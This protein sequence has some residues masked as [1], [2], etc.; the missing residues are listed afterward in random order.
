MLGKIL[1][2]LLA[3]AAVFG[4]VNGSFAEFDNFL[5]DGADYTVTFIVGIAGSICFFCGMANVA[6]E[7]GLTEKL[8]KLFSPVFKRLLPSA[9]KNKKTSENTILNISSNILG[10]GNAATPFGISAA[11]G[12]YSED[13][14]ISRSLAL[15]ILFNTSSVQ[16]IPS[17][18]I[19]VRKAA[20]ASDP[21]GVILPVF[22]TQV[23]SAVLAVLISFA[24]FGREEK[25]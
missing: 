25:K 15:F 7:A 5:T 12:I 3:A 22:I 24:F 8:S 20:G 16:I 4:I 9:F 14:R 23:V 19:A 13:K 1:I 21:A 10:L 11:R 2:I 17:T 6:S 18:V